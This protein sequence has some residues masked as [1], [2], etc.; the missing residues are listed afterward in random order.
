MAS[1]PTSSAPSPMSAATT[2]QRSC[3]WSNSPSMIWPQFWQFGF[4]ASPLGSGYTPFYADSCQHPRHPVIPPAP[5]DPTGQVGD[6]EAAA[7]LMVRVTEEVLAL[8]QECQALHK[9]KFDSRRLDKLFAVGDEVLL[10]TEHTP[11][12]ALDGPLQVHAYPAPS[13][14]RLDIPAVSRICPNFNVECLCPCLRRQAA[15]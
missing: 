3:R 14:F 4:L 6:S 2:G 5:S 9:A 11:L 1:S 8:Q 10:D 13:T 12:P 7:H 15:L